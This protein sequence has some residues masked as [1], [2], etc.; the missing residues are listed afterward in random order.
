MYIYIYCIDIYYLSIR[1][2]ISYYSCLYF[3]GPPLQ[4]GFYYD[5]YMGSNTVNE[6]DMKTIET[7]ASEVI[8]KKYEFQR[9]VSTSLLQ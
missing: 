8:K 6:T 7:K 4:A 5:S 2:C 1:Y 9:L 3:I